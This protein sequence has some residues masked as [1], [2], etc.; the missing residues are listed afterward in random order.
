MFKPVKEKVLTP[1]YPPQPLKGWSKFMS[2]WKMAVADVT[3]KIYK[4]HME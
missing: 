2:I 1:S 3:K 4:S